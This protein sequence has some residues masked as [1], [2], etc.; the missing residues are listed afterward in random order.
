[1]PYSSVEEMISLRPVGLDSCLSLAFTCHT[2]VKLDDFTV[3][4]GKTLSVLYMDRQYGKEDVLCCRLQGQQDST[5]LV[6]IPLSVCGQF[7]E[8]ESE[9]RFTVMD[10]ISSPFLRSRRFCFLN[11]TKSNRPLCLSPIYQVHA[12]M[13]RKQSFYSQCN[14]FTTINCCST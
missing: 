7:T 2:D 14:Y 11:T 4:A 6:S 12:L 5:A 1:M 3:S 8:C 10:I 9:E 13:N